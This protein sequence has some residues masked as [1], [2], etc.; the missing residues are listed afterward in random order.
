MGEHDQHKISSRLEAARPLPHNPG[1]SPYN[2][3]SRSFA[4]MAEKAHLP[5]GGVV[6]VVAAAFV[7]LA[8]A[9]TALYND[10][11]KDGAEVAIKD[12]M[13]EFKIAERPDKELVNMGP[14]YFQNPLSLA[15][16]KAEILGR[17]AE[18]GCYSVAVSGG[19]AQGLFTK[20]SVDAKDGKGKPAKLEM[21]FVQKICLK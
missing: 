8:T 5:K 21:G 17:E 2:L 11:L 3:S 4:D 14:L 16:G 12:K 7:A 1:I 9:G 10:R 18:K 6:G 13:R 19:D 15:A 20:S